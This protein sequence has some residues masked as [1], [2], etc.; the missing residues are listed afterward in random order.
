VASCFGLVTLSKC[1]EERV[2]RPLSRIL[3]G[4]RLLS[5]CPPPLQHEDAPGAKHQG[6]V[7]AV[8][9][10]RAQVLGRVEQ[11]KIR[12]KELEQQLQEAAREVTWPGGVQALGW[13]LTLGSQ[14]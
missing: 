4:S 10:E 1:F 14:P 12:V 7:L 2:I 8:E 6:E 9:E 3:E 11:L 5:W 13:G